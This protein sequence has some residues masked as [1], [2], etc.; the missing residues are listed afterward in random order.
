M[1]ATVN[2]ISERAFTKVQCSSAATR[3]YMNE[4]FESTSDSEVSHREV[5]TATEEITPSCGLVKDTNGNGNVSEDT[6]ASTNENQPG[7]LQCCPISLTAPVFPE[8]ALATDVASLLR[9]YLDLNAEIDGITADLLDRA[10]KLEADAEE[11]LLPLIDDMQSLLSQRGDLRRSLMRGDVSPEIA[12]Q[13]LVKIEEL[14]G[15]VEWY[16]NFRARVKDAKSLRTVQRDL[17]RRRRMSLDEHAEGD[18]HTDSN[19]D[20]EGADD[21]GFTEGD[22]NTDGAEDGEELEDAE[23]TE[24]NSVQRTNAN[25]GAEESVRV[26]IKTTKKLLTEFAGKM[27]DVLKGRSIKDV[28]MRIDCAVALVKDLLRAIDEGKLIESPF[29]EAVL[30]SPLQPPVIDVP[31]PASDAVE[32]NTDDLAAPADDPDESPVTDDDA[33]EFSVSA[34]HGEFAVWEQPCK[35]GDIPF[36]ILA[37]R[38]EAKAQAAILAAGGSV[39]GM[40]ARK[41][42]ASAKLQS[43]SSER[44]AGGQGS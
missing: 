18:E 31:V 12:A 37:T 2:F 35:L 38:E 17:A 39:C 28:S 11:M 40:T 33:V 29:C 16:E 27:L 6:T 4:E 41:R 21:G 8:T 1:F 43:V 22:E 15:W 10:T 42:P 23:G 20:S 3:D 36:N 13:L 9:E 19:E 14:P 26:E 5:E 25:H 24:D 7:E 30:P 44:A 34:Y 32:V